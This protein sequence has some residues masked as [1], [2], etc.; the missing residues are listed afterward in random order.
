MKIPQKY[1]KISTT[2]M[3]SLGMSGVMS[4]SLGT[5]QKGMEATLATFPLS[6]AKAFIVALPV[7]FLLAPVVH[8]INSRIVAKEI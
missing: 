3:M 8:K 7:S 5:M 2:I 4:F 1:T 6:W